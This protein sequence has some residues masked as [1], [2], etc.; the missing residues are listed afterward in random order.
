MASLSDLARR[1][2]RAPPPSMTDPGPVPSRRCTRL[3][4]RLLHALVALAPTLAMAA[5]DRSGSYATRGTCDGFPRADLTTPA[6]WCVGI[7]ADAGSGLRFP[8]RV[9]EVAPGRLWIV[10]MG[11]WEPRQGRLLEL[12]WPGAGAAA[13]GERPRPTVLASGLDRPLGM[14]RGP[15][16]RIWIGEAGR[17]VRTA[18][19]APGA[20]VQLESVVDGLPADGAHPLKELAFGA[21]GTLFVNVGSATDAC[22]A[23]A[24]LEKL[25]PL[26]CPELAGD[27][28]RAAVWAATFDRPGWALR[29]LKPHATGLRNSLALAVVPGTDRL[30]QGENSIDWPDAAEPPEELNALREGAFHGWPYCVGDRQPA[31]GYAGR[32]DCRGRS[33]GAAMRWPA[34]A[35]P[36]QMQAY[37]AAAPHAFAGQ[38][39]VAFHGHRGGG[40]RIASFALDGGGS[41]SGPARAWI[42]GWSPKAGVRPLGTPAGFTVDGSG[43]LLVVEDRNRTLLVLA[44]DGQAARG[45]GASG[46]GDG[47]RPVGSADATASTAA[48]GPST[49][50]AASRPR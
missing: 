22:R 25:P 48:A 17:I 4:R 40:H 3:R 30:L 24:G 38:L 34:H 35:A 29:G 2:D 28:P 23:A 20:A 39:V 37:A 7:V 31:R 16:G 45:V 8:R 18:V 26:P 41:P 15:D 27:R 9:L 12:S 1:R 19:G 43:R 44:P 6:G 33:V 36:L 47:P 14:V 10:D 13:R 49:R 21:D 32:F 50:P 42:A 11:S 46:P 5:G